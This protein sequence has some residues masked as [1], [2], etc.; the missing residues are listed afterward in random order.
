M[1]MFYS[2]NFD[3]HFLE[4]NFSVHLDSLGKKFRLLIVQNPIK[5]SFIFVFFKKFIKV[6]NA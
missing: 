1:G 6:L 3:G 4:L 2:R 5:Y